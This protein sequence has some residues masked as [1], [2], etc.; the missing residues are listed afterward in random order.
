MDSTPWKAIVGMAL[1]A[2]I[3]IMVFWECKYYDY[4]LQW[5]ASLHKDIFDELDHIFTESEFPPPNSFFRM[6]IS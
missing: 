1:Q 4:K 3:F 6:Y 2:I 5:L